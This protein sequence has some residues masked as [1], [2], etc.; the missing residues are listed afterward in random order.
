MTMP[1]TTAWYHP[2]KIILSVFSQDVSVEDMQSSNQD[3]VRFLREAAP[4]KVHILV[5]IRTLT[6]TAISLR[7]IRDRLSMF[8]EPNFGWMLIVGD[9]PALAK[10]L[11]SAT[12]QL[13][14]IPIRTYPTIEAALSYLE[15]QDAQVKE[16][17]LP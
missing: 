2:S 5:D 13:F 3:A 1:Y 6:S 10:F 15:Q 7:D 14:H 17:L 4:Q 16:R 8:Q 9:P 12:G 11:I